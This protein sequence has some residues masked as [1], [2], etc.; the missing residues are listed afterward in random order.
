MYIIIVGSGRFGYPLAKSAVK[1]GNDVVI[2]EKDEDRAK[3]ISRELDA[4]VLNGDGTEP[5]IIEQARI[6]DS[7][8]IVSS[9]SDASVNVLVSLL[10]QDYDVPRVAAV[11]TSS[12]YE[13]ILQKMGV[14]VVI[15][16]QQ[17]VSERMMNHISNPQIEDF[18]KLGE[19]KRVA[20]FEV[21]HGSTLDGMKISDIDSTSIP[22]EI[23]V[24]SILRGDKAIIPSGDSV[25]K[26][27]DKVALMISDSDLQ[28][29]E[30]AFRS[31]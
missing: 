21:E 10:A 12:R 26:S 19:N 7:D 11:A 28:Q 18:L 6:E 3:K 25:I 20:V 16:P 14:D 31:S 17:I 27:G 29:I 13:N 15:N 8:I 30:K 23:L 5:D 4:T 22:D 9:V 2:V 1:Q 24:A